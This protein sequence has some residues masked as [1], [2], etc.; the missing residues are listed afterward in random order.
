M[1]N[2]C[3]ICGAETKKTIKGKPVCGECLRMVKVLTETVEDA[4]LGFAD[5]PF[6]AIVEYDRDAAAGVKKLR[7]IL[8]TGA[9]RG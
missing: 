7:H 9:D 1:E 8:I 6:R 2:E 3:V 4:M 5:K